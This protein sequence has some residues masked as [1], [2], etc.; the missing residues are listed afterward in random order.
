MEADGY[1]SQDKK[2]DGPARRM[3]VEAAF[4]RSRRP[5]FLDRQRDVETAQSVEGHEAGGFRRS[6]FRAGW[7]RGRGVRHGFLCF[8]LLM[9]TT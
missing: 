2:D 7:R 1:H 4:D 6:V 8:C 5:P 3:E 9:I